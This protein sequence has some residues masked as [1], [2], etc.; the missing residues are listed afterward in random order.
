MT[1]VL[2]AI[3]TFDKAAGHKTNL[4][5]SYVFANT[6]AARDEL[7]KHNAAG[8]DTSIVTIA[9]MVGHDITAKRSRD[10]RAI[11]ERTIKATL[12]ATK[13]TSMMDITRKQRT[14]LITN[15]VIP[16][17]VS[18]T[19]WATP[20]KRAS[21]TLKTEVLKAIWG[22][23]RKLRSPEMVL[24]VINNP[25]RADPLGALVYKRLSDARRLLNK[26]QGRLHRAI[27]TYEMQKENTNSTHQH[28]VD[29]TEHRNEESVQRGAL[30]SELYATDSIYNKA[31]G[32][33]TGM[34]QAA[35]L[36]GGKLD[37]D[38]EG[39]YIAFPH[40]DK[41]LHINKRSQRNLETKSYTDH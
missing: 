25:T 8:K 1:E 19:M 12:R 14:K 28:N 23:G 16:A 20:S 2:N 6:Q 3:E 32:P 31:N 27:H 39:F 36:L 34:K 38:K 11:T 10:T 7:R 40:N 22:K 18:G 4:S 33:I 17:A 15:A 13:A 5:K 24:A 26:N 37:Y 35:A 21:N 9:N 29:D 41:P 30:S